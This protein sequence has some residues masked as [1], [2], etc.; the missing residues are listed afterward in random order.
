MRDNVRKSKLFRCILAVTLAAGLALP[1]MGAF[2]Y[3]EPNEA[4]SDSLEV[5][6]KSAGDAVDGAVE[7]AASSD[8]TD[9]GASAGDGAAAEPDAPDAPNASEGAENVT[10]G[11]CLQR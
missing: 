11:G 6:D 8:V 7:G 2:A 9:A 4:A 1:S 5:N 10:G 3:G